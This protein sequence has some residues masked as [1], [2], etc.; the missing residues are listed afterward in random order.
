[1][2]EELATLRGDYKLPLLVAATS[3]IVFSSTILLSEKNIR[4]LH[5]FSLCDKR[6]SFFKKR[7]SNEITRQSKNI[8]A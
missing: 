4:L 7:Y 5:D 3:S 2:R 6:S 8:C 1:M